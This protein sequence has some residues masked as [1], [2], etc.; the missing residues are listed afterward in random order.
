MDER[1]VCSLVTSV[2]RMRHAFAGTHLR[3]SFVAHARGREAVGNSARSKKT[4]VVCTDANVLR[5][6]VR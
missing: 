6:F 5:R 2:L 3:E 4:Y 1:S